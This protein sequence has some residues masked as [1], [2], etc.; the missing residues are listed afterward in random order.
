MGKDF[1]F[2]V[3]FVGFCGWGWGL[4]SYYRLLGFGWEFSKYLGVGES[5]GVVF[6]WRWR[7]EFIFF[8]VRFLGFVLLC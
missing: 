8:F 3:Y 2:L 4:K 6:V 7:W 5:F 1:K